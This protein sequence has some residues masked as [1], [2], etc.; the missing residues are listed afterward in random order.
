MR[1]ETTWSAISTLR[2]LTTAAVDHSLIIVEFQTATK[3]ERVLE[4]FIQ[5]CCDRG[6]PF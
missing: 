4:A 3:T 6:W 2:L 5:A 1:L